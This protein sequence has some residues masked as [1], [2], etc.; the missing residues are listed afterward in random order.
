M[1]PGPTEANDRLSPRA[2]SEAEVPGLRRPLLMLTSRALRLTTEL[3]F[4]PSTMTK[5]TWLVLGGPPPGT[6]SWSE[7]HCVPTFNCASFGD[8]TRTMDHLAGYAM[9]SLVL[10]DQEN[11]DLTPS[12]ERAVPW[13]FVARAADLVR[14]TPIALGAAPALT[15]AQRLLP[16]AGSAESAYLGCGLIERMAPH[17]ALF[18]IQC[19]RLERRPELFANFVKEVAFR[20]RAAN[21]ELVVTAGVSTN[22]TGAEVFLE[23]LLHCI[24]LTSQ[25][26]DGFWVNVPRPGRRCPHCRPENPVLATALLNHLRVVHRDGTDPSDCLTVTIATPG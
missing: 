8:V 17:V 21:P 4:D 16:Q 5:L 20:A 13:D 25:D 18:H 6:N 7:A 15:L 12:P 23:Q 11:W 14:G 19:Q 2:L 24:E 3:G 1:I 22:P 10:Y 26:V 9:P